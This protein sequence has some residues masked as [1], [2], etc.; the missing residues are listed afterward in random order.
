MKGALRCFCV[1][2]GFGLLL[3]PNTSAYAAGLNLKL[4][5]I[6]SPIPPGATVT[7]VIAAEPGAVRTPTRQTHSFNEVQLQSR[8]VGPNG[9]VKWSWQVLTGKNPGGVRNVRVTCTKNNQ[10][11]SINTAFDVR[12]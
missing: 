2:F 5:S 12:F 10:Q 3:S 4:L 6:T 11:A 1:G 7:M 8:V 9:R